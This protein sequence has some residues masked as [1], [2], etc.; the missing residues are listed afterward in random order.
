MVSR[1]TFWA[2]ETAKRAIA[3]AQLGLDTVGH[4]I[5]NM[6]TPGYTRQRVDQVSWHIKG[7][8]KFVINHQFYSGMG[9]K[10]TGISQIRDPFLDARY[11][12]EAADFGMYSV[13]TGGL[14]DLNKIFDE[15]NKDAGL[16]ITMNDLIESVRL[17]LSNPTDESYAVVIRSEADKF[18]KH[19]NTYAQN[20]QN[21]LTQNI[22]DMRTLVGD[23]LNPMLSEIAYLSDQI[24]KMEIY[25]N[26]A[27]ELR[28][29]RNLLLDNLSTYVDIEVTEPRER[30]TQDV[31]I[32]RLSVALR[33]SKDSEGKPIMLISEDK[34]TQFYVDGKNEIQL[35]AMM[36]PEQWG[37]LGGWEAKQP[38]DDGFP[39]LNPAFQSR[40]IYDETGNITQFSS[41][42]TGGLKGFMDVIHGDGQNGEFR[43]IPYAVAYLDNLAR[44]FADAINGVNTSH[45]KSIDADRIISWGAATHIPDPAANG[46]FL[47]DQF[48]NPVL[49][50]KNPD[51]AVVYR[52]LTDGNGAP[53]AI[54]FLKPDGTLDI[55]EDRTAAD[56]ARDMYGGLQGIEVRDRL[57]SALGS[58]V[59]EY[60][61][62]NVSDLL[63]EH[64]E[65]VLSLYIRS[66]ASPYSM[67]PHMISDP[68]DPSRL[69]QNPDYPGDFGANLVVNSLAR[70]EIWT[71]LPTLHRC[72]IS[73]EYYDPANPDAQYIHSPTL[74]A[75]G[76]PVRFLR[77]P[78]ALPGTLG[79][80]EPM[81][82]TAG[83][84]IVYNQL[85]RTHHS[86][87]TLED[88][89]GITAA[90]I[91][92]SSDWRFNPMEVLLGRAANMNAD[93]NYAASLLNALETMEFSIIPGDKPMTFHGAI[94]GF[95]AIMGLDMSI[96]GN[97]FGTT[98]RVLY[99]I[100][101]QRQ[102]ISG[103]SENEEA[104]EMMKYSNHYNAAVR[105][106]TVLDEALDT[107]INGMGRV[108]R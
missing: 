108:G 28:D 37:E 77:D 15:F 88:T 103:V 27:N 98:E 53:L 66:N 59:G 93:T 83:R 21:I 97:L 84:P 54:H 72:I 33:N 34:Y 11:R 85:D 16:T 49:Y 5:A 47:T 22:G 100:D 1:P 9:A 102:S 30:I 92:I 57:V 78:S 65:T 74:D 36:L 24:M 73:G 23:E 75:Q 43:G 95:Q 32:G 104:I 64:A 90:N 106:M 71:P 44:V 17:A 67:P 76:S 6:E 79:Y 8:S 61:P 13:Q 101:D 35:T 18:A 96:T 89:E 51:G 55:S 62:A 68:A 81:R 70:Q 107:I 26:P 91:A 40:N 14:T 86:Q 48:R 99:T 41:L 25:G 94:V 3:N 4:N 60:D 63:E 82:D 56:I 7:M 105:Y 58:V 20:V 45:V 29:R 2:F 42:L 52:G 19:L 38:G 46:S 12:Q 69:I 80:L 87:S 50:A 39:Q 10:A 31:S